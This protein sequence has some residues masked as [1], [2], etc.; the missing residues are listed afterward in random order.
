AGTKAFA[1]EEAS[2][3]PTPAVEAIA[4]VNV[5][6]ITS[7]SWIAPPNAEHPRA[8]QP[9]ANEL[10]AG[11][12]WRSLNWGDRPPKVRRLQGFERDPPSLVPWRSRFSRRC[13][14]HC[15]RESCP[16]CGDN[17]FP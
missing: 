12:G 5:L 7:S 14:R 11:G 4:V 9:D 6:F 1:D 10:R 16:A 8:R 13:K 15:A 2:S 17:A 3:R